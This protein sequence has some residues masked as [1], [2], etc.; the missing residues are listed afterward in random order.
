MSRQKKQKVNLF[1]VANNI[2]ILKDSDL[3][4]YSIQIEIQGD[5]DLEVEAV[6]GLLNTSVLNLVDNAI[7]WL[8]AKKN[9]LRQ[10]MQD[11]VPKII[12]E[13]GLNTEN[14]PFLKV[15]DNGTGFTD[16]FE[17]LTEPYYS[18]KL[19]GLG[20]GLYLVN[21]IMIRFGGRFYGYNEKGATFELIFN[22][23]K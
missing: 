21:E 2:Q 10:E 5:K 12:I 15:S 13:I 3:K 17:L 20:L 22:S 1:K 14:K 6:P 4:K 19:D 8:R 18:K 23:N 16:P 7:Y 11:F 9:I